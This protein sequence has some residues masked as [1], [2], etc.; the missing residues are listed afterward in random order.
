MQT[1]SATTA[2]MHRLVAM[3][4]DIMTGD[5][6]VRDKAIRELK[7]IRDPDAIPSLEAA[8]CGV[9]VRP[10]WGVPWLRAWPRYGHAGHRLAGSSCGACSRPENAR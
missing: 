9:L 4:G 2:W 7:A 10:R 3:R 8:Y 1:Q 6:I 5:A